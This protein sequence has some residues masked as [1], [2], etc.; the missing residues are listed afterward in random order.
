M[1]KLIDVIKQVIASQVD[2]VFVAIGLLFIL[3]AIVVGVFKQYW[4]IAGVNTASKKDLAKIDLEYVGKYFGIFLG[5][6]GFSI[7]IS[8]FIFRYLNI[9]RYFHN[10][11]LI[12][13]IFLVVFMFVYGYIKK[14]RINKKDWHE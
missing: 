13:T 12:A 9:M 14:D 6:Y 4:L 3:I 10:F 7:F 1:D 2:V 11:F 8:P 5:I